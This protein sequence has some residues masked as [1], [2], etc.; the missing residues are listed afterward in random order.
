MRWTDL[1]EGMVGPLD[2][3]G[4]PFEVVDAA[5]GMLRVGE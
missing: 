3:F 1:V 4:I 2:R 5:W